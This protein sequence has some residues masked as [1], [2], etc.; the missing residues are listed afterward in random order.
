MRDI[1]ARNNC[2]SENHRYPSPRG[3]RHHVIAILNVVRFASVAILGQTI[4]VLSKITIEDGEPRTR[5]FARGISRLY[6]ADS[7]SV[8]LTEERSMENMP[9]PNVPANRVFSIH[10]RSKTAQLVGPSFVGDQLAPPSSLANT[11]RSVPM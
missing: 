2:A 9:R 3:G 1:R 11:P 5:I 4:A 8:E 10:C 7:A 6:G